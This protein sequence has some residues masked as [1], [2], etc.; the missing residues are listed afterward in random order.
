MKYPQKEEFIKQ[1]GKEAW[2]KERKKLYDIKYRQ[3]NKEKRREQDKIY[4]NK[5]IEEKR[6]YNRN[7]E[8][9]RRKIDIQFKLRKSIRG[10]INKLIKLQYN[11]EY[12]EEILG[13][14]IQKYKEYLE[15]L[16]S[17]EMT[18]DNYGEVWQIDH[19]I[20]CRAF[21]LTDEEQLKECFNYKNTQP[22][23]KEE[24][25][26]KSD[27]LPNGILARNLKNP[28]LKNSV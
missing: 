5:H 26:S 11:S 20:P 1:F 2:L 17:E 14:S 13:I 24:N 16:F 28:I 27:K 9:N 18:W 3:A 21:D 25:L 12:L 8:S 7:Y 6:K 23:L 22:L 4:W 19:I 15:S 10:R